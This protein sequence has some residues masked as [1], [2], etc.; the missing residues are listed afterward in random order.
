MD[1]SQA[2]IVTSQGTKI[3]SANSDIKN[4]DFVITLMRD[5]PG[6]PRICSQ[7]RKD[8]YALQSQ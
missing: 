4:D 1:L 5:A 6:Q 7:G 8:A 3:T 2:P